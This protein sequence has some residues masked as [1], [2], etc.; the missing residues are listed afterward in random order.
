MCKSKIFYTF[1][2]LYAFS[3]DLHFTFTIFKEKSFKDTAKGIF[4]EIKGYK[5]SEI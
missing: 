4:C 1:T 3:D 2:G 5:N